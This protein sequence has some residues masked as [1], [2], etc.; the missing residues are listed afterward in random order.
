LGELQSTGFALLASRSMHLPTLWA[1]SSADFCQNMYPTPAHSSNRII[2]MIAI[3]MT[4]PRRL[5][6][7]RRT[8]GIGSV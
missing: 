4:A 7:G 5:P 1:A 6:W 3:T 2:A 8:P